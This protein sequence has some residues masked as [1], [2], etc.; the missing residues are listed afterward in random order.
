MLRLTKQ[1][2][3]LPEILDAEDISR[4]LKFS[5]LFILGLSLASLIGALVFHEA[6]WVRIFWDSL[7]MMTASALAIWLLGRRKVLLA[8]YIAVIGNGVWL[9]WAAWKGA[10]VLGITYAALILP[11]LTAALFLG[12]RAGFLVA[13]ASS[14]YGLL[15]LMAGRLGWLVNIENPISDF[16]AWFSHTAFFF[17]AAQLI[18]I[19]LWQVERALTKMRAEIEERAQTETE[20][21]H[22]N[23][24]L[25]QRIAERTAQLAESEERYR[26]ISTVSSDYMFSS[27][28]NADG[29]VVL[30]WVAGAFEKITGYSRE[31][32]VAQ[33]GWRATLHPDDIQTDEQDIERLK[34]N[35]P[36]TSEVRVFDRQGKLRWVRVSAH[37]RWDA[38]ANRLIGVYGS[39]QEI[40]ER[41]QAEEALRASE[42]RFRMLVEQL[43][44]VVYLDD[45]T[46]YG[47]TVY[48]SPQFE[49]MT[50]YRPDEAINSEID[51]W[52]ERIHPDDRQ[53]AHDAYHRCFYAGERLN[54]EYRF[55]ARNHHYIWVQDRAIRVQDVQARPEYILGVFHDITE[56]KLAE[57]RLRQ[58]TMQLSV[59]YLLGQR[60]SAARAPDEIYRAAHQAVENLFPTEAFFIALTDE[61]RQTIEYVYLIDKGQ[62]YPNESLPFTERSLTTYVIQTGEML[63]AA[64]E[65][66]WKAIDAGSGL[67]GTGEDTLSL[68]IAPLKPG[69]T[70]IGVISVQ[71]YQFGAYTEEHRQ[72]FMTLANQVATAIKNSLLVQSLRLQAAALNAAANAIVISD[73]TGI[74]QWVNPAFTAM[75]GYSSREAIGQKNSLL[76]SG[77]QDQAF[78]KNLWDTLAQGK[79]WQ[80]ELVNRRKD[81]SLYI[82]EQIITPVRDEHGN[83][84]RYISIKQDITSRKQAEERETRRRQM[85]EK[86]IDL[87]KSV[88]K[89]TDLGQCL[90]EIHRNVQQGLG[91]DRVGLFDYDPVQ[92]RVRGLIG[93]NPAGKIEDTTWFSEPVEAYEGWVKAIRESRGIYLVENFSANDDLTHRENM[94]GVAQHAILAGWVGDKPV[95]LIGVDNLMTRRKF[96][97]EQ[98]EALELFAGYAALAIENAHWNAQ[99]EQRVNE[100][101]SQLES[102]NQELEALAYTIAHDLRIPA[103]AMHGFASI[104][105]ETEAGNL[106][107]ASLQRLD[108]IRDNAKMMGQQVDDL[109]EFMRVGRAVLHIQTVNMN[110]LAEMARA[111]LENKMEGRNIR[112]QV[113]DLP[114]CQGDRSLLRQVWVNLLENAIKFTRS[115][116]AAEIEIGVREVQGQTAYFVRDN[117]VGFDMKFVNNLFG[118][119]QRL[120]HSEEYEGT[121]MG[122]AIAQRILQRHGGRIWAEAQEGE[123]ATFYFMLG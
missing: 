30:D 63:L 76:R 3:G 27:R 40:T 61:Q 44:V 26:L 32:Y 10:G 93:T 1:W 74:I 38:H 115:H 110:S 52:L 95:L 34:K 51:F 66:D 53:S 82:E 11:V 98:L 94:R 90:R 2:P 64:T 20:M 75:T 105:K 46:E 25:E 89:I 23:A 15:L 47:K 84:F 54:R 6:G 85:M 108:R 45:A 72:I 7:I 22:L 9:A 114:P 96:S 28:I 106:N 121:G 103:R 12:R 88:T 87:G 35:Q 33:G 49:A 70:V 29:S 16:F 116:P 104:L 41:K 123:G 117:G 91:F 31:E 18:S 19:S 17:I 59:L 100:R 86:V 67:Y 102:A 56:R 101:T 68:M 73:E 79:V 107:F 13:L 60:M 58:Q 77:L 50:G 8:V 119:F 80:G 24:E 57:E 99:L 83:I 109:L 81:G 113:Q 78:Y 5:L 65:D 21:R 62:R 37:P 120:H 36:V 112:L 118:A 122:L 14:G 4:F 92:N 43:P 55:R 48:I 71:S 111:S 42:N 69:D 39:V 97:P